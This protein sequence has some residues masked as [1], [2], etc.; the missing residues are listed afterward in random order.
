[1]GK[2]VTYGDVPAAAARPGQRRRSPS[3][4]PKGILDYLAAPRCF[5]TIYHR[6]SSGRRGSSHGYDVTDPTTV[7]AGLG[8]PDG[9]AAVRSGPGSR[10]WDRRRHRAQPPRC[11]TRSAQICGGGTCCGSVGESAYFF[12]YRLGT[13]TRT[14]GSCYRS[15]G[16]DD[17]ID[18]LVV[19]GEVFQLGD[20]EFPS[21]YRDR[22]AAG[23]P[24]P[25]ALPADG[26]AARRVC[27]Y[28]RFF[29]V[30][31][32]A[33]L[34]QED[35]EVFAA[36]HRE[37][38]RWF[39]EGL[40][41]GVRVDHPRRSGG[42]AGYLRRLRELIGPGRLPRRREDPRPRRGRSMTP[43]RSTAPPA[44]T[45]CGRS[46]GIRRSRRTRN[47]VPAGRFG[48]LCGDSGS[49]L[50]T[51]GRLPPT[52]ASELAR[53][54]R[55]VATAAGADHR[56]CQAVTAL[57]YQHRGL[58]LRL[59][60]PFGGDA[61]RDRRHRRRDGLT[62]P[63]RWHWW[64][65]R[66]TT[67]NRPSV[68]S[69]CGAGDREGHRGPPVLPGPDAGLAQRG[70]RG[71]PPF[72]GQRRGV[73]PPRRG[74]RRPLAHRHDHP[75]HHDTKRGEDVA[76]HRVLSQ[77]PDYGAQLVA[78]WSAV[79]PTRPGIPVCSCGRT[80]SVWPATS[81]VDDTLRDRLHGYAEKAIREA[82]LHV[83]DRSR[84]RLREAGAH[85]ARRRAGRSGSRGLTELVHQLIRMRRATHWDE[86]VV[87]H[88]SGVPDVYQG[89]ELWEDNLVD[90][91]NRRPVDFPSC[92]AALDG[93][94]HPKMRESSTPLSHSG[95]RGRRPSWPAATPVVGR[96]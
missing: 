34:R 89:T 86:V 5:R 46:A 82:H 2:Q 71:S 69:S 39:S 29:S 74:A 59:S 87:P 8:G 65:W 24:R 78:D 11:R 79:A 75:V 25:S 73:P 48:R 31:S 50:R 42:P 4:T 43:C 54:C 62:W 32:L 56:R 91:D 7:S 13:S 44:T 10:S 1:M 12:R 17:D 19:D 53:V 88:R 72:R 92:R 33:G 51:Q 30:T 90:P 38:A 18:H 67:V 66:W 80:S 94:R 23:D 49:G 14:G 84:R 52:P 35:P 70:R 3:K 26:A 21:G 55:V 36:S 37:V 93:L 15:W 68:S 45:H 63:R 16:S 96:R 28:R 20:K 95:A 58:P 41:D 22:H 27:G 81:R 9:L 6:R 57:A 64:P 61:D 76:P 83:L 60:R 40:V 47:I 85:L 77:C